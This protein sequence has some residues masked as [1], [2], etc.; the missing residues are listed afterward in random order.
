MVLLHRIL[1]LEILLEKW[2]NC[3][4]LCPEEVNQSIV[5]VWHKDDTRMIWW[6]NYPFW[7]TIFV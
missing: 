7:W 6:Q 4:N 5:L 3:E 2:E 1:K